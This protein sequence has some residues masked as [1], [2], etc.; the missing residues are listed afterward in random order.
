MQKGLKEG[1]E[2]W[3]KEMYMSRDTNLL[4]L[5]RYMNHFHVEGIVSPAEKRQLFLRINS[6]GYFGD[7]MKVLTKRLR[8]KPSGLCNPVSRKIAELA[9]KENIIAFAIDG[10]VIINGDRK[11]HVPVVLS[12]PEKSRI[13]LLVLD[14]TLG[15]FISDNPTFYGTWAQY[16]NLTK[17]IPTARSRTAMRFLRNGSSPLEYIEAY[18]A[19]N[20]VLSKPIIEGNKIIRSYVNPFSDELYAASGWG[21]LDLAS[22]WL[23]L[24]FGQVDIVNDFS[25]SLADLKLRYREWP[26]LEKDSE[27]FCH[28]FERGFN[29][30]QDFH[31]LFG[32]DPAYF[33]VQE[34][35]GMG[36]RKEQVLDIGADA[37]GIP[38]LSFRTDEA[39]YPC[40]IRFVKDDMMSLS[41]NLIGEWRGRLNV[42]YQK[43]CEVFGQCYDEYLPGII[44]SLVPGGFLVF[45]PYTQG[46]NCEIPYH[47]LNGLDWKVNMKTRLSLS[48]DTDLASQLKFLGE[49]SPGHGWS[50]MVLQKSYNAPAKPAASPLAR[51]GAIP[52]SYFLD[53]LKNSKIRNYVTDLMSFCFGQFGIT[54]DEVEIMIEVIIRYRTFKGARLGLYKSGFNWIE[55]GN[56]YHDIYKH[57]STEVSPK[58]KYRILQTCMWPQCPKGFR[59]KTVIIDIGCGKHRI[60]K[61]LIWDMRRR[62][63]GI[64]ERFIPKI[65][66]VDFA[67]KEIVVKDKKGKLEYIQKTEADADKVPV[68]GEA[69]ADKIWIISALHHMPEKVINSIL[70]EAHRLLKANGELMILEDVALNSEKPK[71]DS[72]LLASQRI[73]ELSE[74]ESRIAFT[75]FDWHA[76]CVVGGDT[77]VPMPGSYYSEEKWLRVFSLA[78]FEVKKKRYIGVYKKKFSNL[79]HSVF[80]L[81]KRKE[82]AASPLAFNTQHRIKGIFMDSERLS[83]VGNEIAVLAQK[84]YPAIL[85]DDVFVF[86]AIW[87]SRKVVIDKIKKIIYVGDYWVAVFT[88]SELAFIVGHEIGHIIKPVGFIKSNII[89]IFP[90]ILI[91]L[92]PMCLLSVFIKDPLGLFITGLFSGLGFVIFGNYLVKHAAKKHTLAEQCPSDVIG[93][94]LAYKA[95]YNPSEFLPALRKLNVD[96]NELG[97]SLR[98]KRLEEFIASLPDKTNPE[99]VVSSSLAAAKGAP[100][101]P[102]DSSVLT[103]RAPPLWV[104]ITCSIVYVALFTNSAYAYIPPEHTLLPQRKGIISVSKAQTDDAGLDSLLIK[105]NVPADIARAISRLPAISPEKAILIWNA[106]KDDYLRGQVLFDKGSSLAAMLVWEKAQSTVNNIL[107]MKKEVY[108]APLCVW[109]GIAGLKGYGLVNFEKAKTLARK[110]IEVDPE[111]GGGYFLLGWL[112]FVS[113]QECTLFRS[114][115]RTQDLSGRIPY[116]HLAVENLKKASE[117]NFYDV[118]LYLKRADILL[119]LAEIENKEDYY[120]EAIADF[121]LAL[122]YNPQMETILA[123]N[124]DIAYC[125]IKLN[126]FSQALKTITNIVEHISGN[127]PQTKRLAEK[128]FT[129]EL[130]Q[131]YAL[132]GVAHLLAG[133]KKDA[134]DDFEKASQLDPSVL[135]AVKSRFNTGSSPL[136]KKAVDWL[137]RPKFFE[138]P[139][140]YRKLGV[141]KF[142]LVSTG[143]FSSLSNRRLEKLLKCYKEWLIW[144]LI[145]VLIVGLFSAHMLKCH[146]YVTAVLFSY[147]NLITYIY[148]ML[149][150]RY[151]MLRVIL[152]LKKREE[153]YS[154]SLNPLGSGISIDTHSSSPLTFSNPRIQNPYSAAEKNWAKYITRDSGK[155]RNKF[156]RAKGIYPAV[157]GVR[158]DPEWDEAEGCFHT[159]LVDYQGKECAWASIEDFREGVSIN[160]I[161]IRDDDKRGNGFGQAL[162]MELLGIY[163]AV[164]LAADE[165]RRSISSDALRMAARMDAQGYEVG[166]EKD[167]L[168]EGNNL[169]KINLIGKWFFV[170]CIRLA[171]SPLQPKADPCLFGRQAL[172]AEALFIWGQFCQKSSSSIGLNR[173]G[174]KDVNPVC[175]LLVDGYSTRDF[176]KELLLSD[177]LRRVGI[178]DPFIAEMLSF[179]TAANIYEGFDLLQGLVN[180]G[181][182]IMGHLN[183]IFGAELERNLFLL[184]T[185]HN[186][187]PAKVLLN[188]LSLLNGDLCDRYAV[189]LNRF[190]EFQRRNRLRKYAYIMSCAG[191][192]PQIP[193]LSRTLRQWKKEIPSFHRDYKDYIITVQLDMKRASFTI[194]LRPFYAPYRKIKKMSRLHSNDT[195]WRELGTRGPHYIYKESLDS[196]AFLREIEISGI[197]PWLVTLIF[198]ENPYRGMINRPVREWERD[199]NV[200]FQFLSSQCLA[201]SPLVDTAY[202]G[203]LSHRKVHKQIERGFTFDI[204]ED[205][206]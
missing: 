16:Y 13:K 189:Q 133:H 177:G 204:S 171:A 84:E 159:R 96:V 101:T 166:P 66:G 157:V 37:G 206:A 11:P 91:Y 120:R 175:V 116:Y 199:F 43:A 40:R 50:M 160:F 122:K 75:I 90:E 168:I 72:N 34:L 69:I 121:S 39:S 167:L 68:K 86:K 20:R 52:D 173:N 106:I 85:K 36:I 46:G 51:K 61:K 191:I 26:K 73:R 128:Q 81:K 142:R 198:A 107:G 172:P 58:T 135:E 98:V 35:Q 165:E 119:Q 6:S 93:A 80:V 184:S 105:I 79:P 182:I 205:H 193:S 138:S 67:P 201:S 57:Y 178:T 76:N 176:Y 190:V 202:H 181:R 19:L 180:D 152:I 170:P 197:E 139:G 147:F 70:K 195:V 192:P 124:Y 95:G 123:V 113:A 110:A 114:L 18:L 78:G 174:L 32:K 83:T 151:N 41:R 14:G 21:G 3:K 164:Y 48:R 148:P 77:Y 112:N 33:I 136:I 200:K 183:S 115:R 45:N 146:W 117:N 163:K 103:A 158:L 8:I 42:Y 132:R 4:S 154:V 22:I 134:R 108:L 65:I 156:L 149:L 188:L 130:S 5:H 15:Q 28:R 162:T 145:A 71:D 187:H 143:K 100:S 74:E 179:F 53:G 49:K 140:L 126:E 63:K 111:Y 59:A 89:G 31:P 23:A 131:L 87:G 150:D 127:T 94:S 88:N 29:D 62:R 24:H 97:F 153:K 196:P 38:F 155:Y 12:V 56:K 92:V 185:N 161:D 47:L 125:L 194:T 60:G 203:W 55:P 144:R 30:T 2:D 102:M 129:V 44:D 109:I 27:F 169:G 82:A 1:M 99:N 25:I 7:F 186:T 9:R 17:F 104:L 118:S 141:R 137:F 10:H 64:K 54:R